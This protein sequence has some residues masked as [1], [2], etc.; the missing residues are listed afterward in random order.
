MKTLITLRYS[1]GRKLVGS[2]TSPPLSIGVTLNIF[3]ISGATPCCIRK[4]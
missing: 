1:V 2:V 3:R 4:D